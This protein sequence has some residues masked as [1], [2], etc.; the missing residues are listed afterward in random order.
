MDE[1]EL[2]GLLI[3]GIPN[4]MLRN[5]ARIQCFADVQHINR[6]FAEVK[7][8]KA[9]EPDKKAASVEKN[10]STLTRCFNCNSKRHWA[11]ECRKPKREK[12]SCYACGEMGHFGAMCPKNKNGEGNNYVRY[13]EINF[14]NYSKTKFITAFLIDT[15]SPI[16]FIKIS[17]VPKNVIELPVLSSFYGLNNSSLK[18][19]GKILCYVMKNFN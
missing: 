9:H 15:G 17:N 7:L 13:F 6:A 18:T 3:E 2:L 5:Q 16:S 4:Q 11:K 8:P 10:S 1:E 12:G 19:Y 14:M